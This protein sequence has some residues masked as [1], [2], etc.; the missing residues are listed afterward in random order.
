M[1]H[2]EDRLDYVARLIND[3]TAQVVSDRASLGSGRRI[4]VMCA[5]H[6]LFV[7]S[8]EDDRTYLVCRN[9]DFLDEQ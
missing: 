7:S 2:P 6:D 3:M 4:F 5:E 9:C 8:D 1:P